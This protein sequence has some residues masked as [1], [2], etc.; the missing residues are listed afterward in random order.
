M[1]LPV[2]ERHLP[3]NAGKENHPGQSGHGKYVRLKTSAEIMTGVTDAARQIYV[4]FEE[5]TK[6][7][8]M[9]EELRRGINW[10]R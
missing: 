8:E 1:G 2:S 5:R 7:R 6:S 4:N 3:V 9:I 10:F